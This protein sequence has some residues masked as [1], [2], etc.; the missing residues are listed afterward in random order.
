MSFIKEEIITTCLLYM[1]THG[2]LDQGWCIKVS[3]SKK[4]LGLTEYDT[5]T[6]KISKYCYYVEDGITDTILHEIAHV[7]AGYENAHNEVWKDVA[8]NIGCSGNVCADW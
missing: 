5:K 3:N 2:L 4:T 7:I 1:K 8:L 6:I